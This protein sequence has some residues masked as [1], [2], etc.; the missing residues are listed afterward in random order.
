MK[1]LHKDHYIRHSK[2]HHI[3]HQ[4]LANIISFLFMGYLLY[5][6]KL[7]GEE[8]RVKY[9]IPIPNHLGKERK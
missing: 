1:L 9:S 3:I 5:K 2:L 6:I 8:E 7:L 4:F